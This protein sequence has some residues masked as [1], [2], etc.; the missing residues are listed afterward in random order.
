MT[1]SIA[2]I[3]LNLFFIVAVSFRYMRISP[4]AFIIFLLLHPNAVFGQTDSSALR[5]E[6]LRGTVIA[7]ESRLP[8]PHARITISGTKL[9]AIA[10]EN[11]EFRI[12][13]V[14]VGHYIVKASANGYAVSSQEI[15]VGSAHQSILDFELH[16]QIVTGDTL[17]VTGSNA[18]EAINRIAVVSVTPFSIEDVKRYAGAFEDPA[19]MADNFAGV[20]GRG[21]SNNYIVVRGGSPIELLWRLDGIDIPNPNHLGKNGS[22]GGLISAINSDMLGNSD[23]F[24]GAFPAEYGTKM[25]AVFDLHTRNGNS[26]KLE[27]SAQLSFSGMELMAEGPVPYAS[28]SS[29][30]FGFRHS[31]LGFLKQIGILDYDQLPD[32]DDAMMKLHL[33]FGE[34]DILSGT[35]IWG[36]ASIDDKYTTNSELGQ[37]SGILVGGLDWQHIF[38]ESFLTH[39][40]LNHAGNNFSEGIGAGTESIDIGYNTAK[41]EMNYT[42]NPLHNFE[43]GIAAEKGTFTLN[44]NSGEINST[45]SSNFYEAYLNWN[46][47]ITAELV[48]NTGLFSQYI[49]YDSASS[50]EP[51]ISLAWSPNQE[52]SFAIAFGVHRQ[53]EPVQFT[54]AVHYVIGYTLRPNPD[55]M[56]KAE[57]YYKDYSDVPIHASTKDF[58]S[59]MNEGFAERINYYDLVNNGHGKTYGAELTLMKHYNEGYYITATASFVRQQF[60]GSD[61]IWHYGAFDNI[62]IINLLSGYDIH[63]GENSMLT[64]SEKFSIAGGSAYT[65]FDLARSQQEGFAV[66]DSAHAYSARNPPYIRVDINAEFHFNWRATTLT[67]YASILNALDIKNPTYRFLRFDNNGIPQVKEDLDVPIIP[68]LGFRFDF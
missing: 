67:I 42:P 23:F 65:P 7:T 8:L 55:L 59:F 30:L 58:Y 20:F 52:H 47:H 43:A 21:T 50:L 45:Q 24:S 41:L 35:G 66:L 63:L 14:P 9:G 18:L 26:E 68:I 1:W 46:W 19:R 25:S 54:Q 12:A 15:V 64:L 61:G 40:E 32:F 62:Y 49:T 37:G 27:G 57:A 11:G 56:I 60:A 29:F 44:S 53:P 31:T 17:I 4:L 48:L 28:G 36:H 38:S 16:E 51:R 10:N 33:K 34:R 5:G 6:T 39:V 13:R 22:T 2:L 3:H